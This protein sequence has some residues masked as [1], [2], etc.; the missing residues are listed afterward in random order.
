MRRTTVPEVL[1]FI[2]AIYED[3]CTG[4]CLHIAMDDGNLQ[5]N[6]LEF[7]LRQGFEH[8]HANCVAAAL[9]LLGM[10]QTQRHFLYR[11]RYPYTH[12]KRRDKAS[13]SV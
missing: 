12:Y 6:H 1:P 10:T 7:C 8:G 4:C 2:A 13:A 3:H 5:D 11:H 9:M